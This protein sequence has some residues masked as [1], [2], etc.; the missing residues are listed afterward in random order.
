MCDAHNIGLLH[1]SSLRFFRKLS[2]SNITTEL[3]YD[4][5]SFVNPRDPHLSS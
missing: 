5:R 1:L 3:S 2:I 4:A